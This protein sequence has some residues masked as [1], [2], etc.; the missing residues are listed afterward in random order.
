MIF[1]I[2]LPRNNQ[3]RYR[4]SY[5]VGD[6]TFDKLK[7]YYFDSYGDAKEFSNQLHSHNFPYR[8]YEI[9]ITGPNME[10]GLILA[11]DLK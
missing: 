11:S 9:T 1:P 3:S 4:V 7:T 5:T 8:Y 10:Y 6:N 2:G